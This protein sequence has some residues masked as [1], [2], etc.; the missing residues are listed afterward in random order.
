MR[1]IIIP[2]EFITLNEYIKA[3]RT[4]KYL[5]AK[6]KKNETLRVQYET[7]DV[8]PLP[9]G[10]LDYTFHW[11]R[12]DRRTDPDNIFHSSKQIFDGLQASGVIEGDG[13]KQIGKITHECFVDKEHPRVEIIVDC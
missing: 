8:Y 7:N 10:K 13:W 6:M 3:E 1:K 12:K 2:G 9:G 4:N 11:Y 5:A